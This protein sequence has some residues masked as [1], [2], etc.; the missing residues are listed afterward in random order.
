MLTY[1]SYL[2]LEELLSLQ[3]PLSDGPTGPAPDEELFILI[4]QTCELWFKALL[5]EFEALEAHFRH[6]D[7]SGAIRASNRV[8]TMLKISTSQFDILE[9]ITPLTFN[10]FRA[11]LGSASGFE[12]AQFREIEFL[13]GQKWAPLLKLYPEDGPEYQRLRARFN[14]PTLWDAFLY[15]LFLHH[16]PVPGALLQ[17][18]VTSALEPSPELQAILKDIY[19]REPLLGHVCE[20]LLEIDERLQAWRYR[21]MKAVERII[22]AKFGTGGSPGASYLIATLKPCFPDLWILRSS[23]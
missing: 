17:R 1:A 7:L 3:K 5:H 6:D 18:D 13:L 20:L 8:V 12:S 19:H 23:L 11:L 9:T 2:H 21:H 16:Y 14:A 10:T 4:H 22:G 15:L